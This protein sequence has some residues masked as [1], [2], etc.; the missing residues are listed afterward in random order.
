MKDFK[1]FIYIWGFILMMIGFG[2]WIIYGWLEFIFIWIPKGIMWFVNN[3][4][5]IIGLIVIIF[6]IIRLILWLD[7]KKYL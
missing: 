7:D 5:S 6:L 1:E 4:G 2:I 3:I